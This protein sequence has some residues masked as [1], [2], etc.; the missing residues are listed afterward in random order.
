M[1]PATTPG[2]TSNASMAF[3]SA[4]GLPILFH[5]DDRAM[6]SWDGSDWTKLPWPDPDNEPNPGFRDSPIVYDSERGRLLTYGGFE[7]P[8]TNC[9]RCND[10]WEWFGT[11]GSW[12]QRGDVGSAGGSRNGHS[13]VHD[14]IRKVTVL[15]GG[16]FGAGGEEDSDTWEYD[17]AQWTRA[18][19]PNDG[20]LPARW[21]HASV[22]DSDRGKVVLFG[23]ANITRATRYSDTWE[24][25]GTE[26]V[27]KTLSLSNPGVR[28]SHKMAY[29]SVRKVTILYGG[30]GVYDY[31]IQWEWDGT[32]W[33]RLSLDAP[34]PER[35]HDHAMVFDPIRKRVVL[36][37]GSTS[38]M[39]NDT[40][41]MHVRGNSCDAVS[42]CHTG[43]C[44]D[45]I[46]CETACDDACESC[47]AAETGGE[48][49]L[50]APVQAGVDPVCD[51]PD[52]PDAGAP[53][54]DAPSD[55]G[56]ETDAEVPDDAG[57]GDTPDDAGDTDASDDAG[58]VTDAG[59]AG[60]DDAS[61]PEADEGLA[62][63]GYG[64]VGG[65]CA[66][67]RGRASDN[68]GW[69]AFGIASIALL[70][71]RRRNAGAEGRVS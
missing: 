53:D 28:H 25:D 17:G 71:A 16:V 11:P 8:T 66:Q 49:G 52:E 63:D 19:A 54:A 13:L 21:L 39:Q 31:D 45:G 9:Q 48:D 27:E 65:G 55:A 18:V 41:E 64:L 30:E 24:Y 61:E 60:D 29:D 40:W 3:D 36:F 14:H 62:A 42:D 7:Y 44:V 57:D 43:F 23:G 26:W 35:R 15:T 2:A 50:C 59:D 10:T 4:A 6:W 58:E 33:R 37:G 46:C 32:S 38:G 1:N 12:A 56:E 47:S 5:P 68:A 20:Y 51:E 69:A 22:F 34:N 67:A 70:L